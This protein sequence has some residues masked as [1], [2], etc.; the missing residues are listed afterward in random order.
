MSWTTSLARWPHLLDQLCA[1]FKHF[2]LA[3]LMRFHGD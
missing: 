2:D 3:A 1:Q